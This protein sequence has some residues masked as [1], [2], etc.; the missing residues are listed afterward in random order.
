MVMPWEQREEGSTPAASSNRNQ[1]SA[2]AYTK[3]NQS[4]V[5]SNEL[6]PV[7]QSLCQSQNERNKSQ[8][9][10]D[11]A[12]TVLHPTNKTNKMHATSHV[13]DDKMTPSKPAI[14][15]S[16][17]MH[18]TTSL[19]TSLD[20]IDHSLPSC[21]SKRAVEVPVPKT[22]DEIGDIL[23]DNS[24]P[25]SENNGKNKVLAH[26]KESDESAVINT[27]QERK[28]YLQTP[29]KI[30]MEK[31]AKAY[32]TNFET[33]NTKM[34]YSENIMNLYTDPSN[35]VGGE[36]KMTSNEVKLTPSKNSTAMKGALS[37]E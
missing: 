30:A 16:N 19:T 23:N 12:D 7:K 34:F 13:F 28:K 24:L 20:I 17:K 27:H 9:F 36:N 2:L 22:K 4:T 21:S 6:L 11:G 32:S 8:V 35:G 29:G 3:S 5:F 1:S 37:W 18:T 25:L 31:G 33:A 26:M 10:S 15:K 14:N